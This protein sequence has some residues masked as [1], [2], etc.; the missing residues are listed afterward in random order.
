MRK[1]S[2]LFILAMFFTACSMKNIIPEVT[3]DIRTE[4]IEAIHPDPGTFAVLAARDKLILAAQN[5][6]I[7]GIKEGERSAG[8]LFTHNG[9]FL[10]RHFTQNGILVLNTVK[11]AQLILFDLNTEKVIYEAKRK[12]V[13]EVIGVNRDFLIS[14]A[15]KE[16]EI[17]NLKNDRDNF[18]YE[19]DRGKVFN[20]DIG[21]DRIFILFERSLL[22]YHTVTRTMKESVVHVAPASDFT[23]MHND[24]YYGDRDRYLVKYSLTRNRVVW[25]FRF[26]KLLLTRPLIMDGILIASPEDNNTYLISPGGTLDHW[27][28][29]GEGRLFDPVLMKEHLAVVHRTQAGISIHY[30]S[31]KKHTFSVFRDKSFRLTLPPVYFKNDLF[32]VGTENEDLQLKLL[33][34]GNKY[35]ADI[36]TSPK[37]NLEAG[38]SVRV[39]IRPV[40]LV[41]PDITAEILNESGE[42][43]F[44]KKSSHMEAPSFAWIP[45]TGGKFTIN[46]T[47]TGED[48][49]SHND[50][51]EILVIDTGK[52]YKDLQLKIHQQCD[53]SQMRDKPEN[54]KKTK[55][56]SD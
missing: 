51:M 27:F 44:T 10:R 6:T 52:I 1:I 53:G 9:G 54:G 50:K 42:S 20:C 46:V 21:T 30:Y 16:L 40:N 12:P 17:L 19:V 28:R 5:G 55:E 31:L 33:R 48:G 2:F 14:L 25:R 29:S 49:S 18:N 3:P 36:S 15:G 7:S 37:E 23:R 43:I 47:S 11:S 34:I 45:V 4:R 38:K 39:L 32:G 35:G 41:K 22:V 26:Q 56:I 24:I 8:I 13:S